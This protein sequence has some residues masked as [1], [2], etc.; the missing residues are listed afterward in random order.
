MIRMA[1]HVLMNLVVTV[2]T[3]VT[4]LLVA[5]CARVVPP[6]APG[7]PTEPRVSWV[8]RSGPQ[9]GSETDVCRSDRPQP[10]VLRATPSRPM[11]VVVSVYMYPAGAPTTYSGA[12]QSTFIQAAGGGGYEAK[13]D[14][15]IEPG[16]L[17]TGVTAS[18]LVTATPGSYEFRIA[19]FAKVPQRMDPYQF[20]ERIPVRVMAG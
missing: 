4:A 11:T 12:F 16:R 14:Y 1:A 17:P 7:S 6:T 2:V 13:A 5:G 10:C 3:V 19:L 8:I 15:E 20:Q 9:G 18:G